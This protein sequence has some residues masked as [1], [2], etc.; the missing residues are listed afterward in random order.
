MNRFLLRFGVLVALVFALGLVGLAPIGATQADATARLTVHNR[1]CP[2]GFSGPDYYGT[3]HDTAPNPGLPFSISGPDAAAATTDAGGNVTFADLT[4]G[5]YAVS[6]G[7]PGEFADVNYFCAEADALAVAY[8]FTETA[9]GITV[10]LP[11]G[12]DVICDWYNTPINLSGLPTPTPA[13]TADLATLT[14]YAAICPAGYNGGSYFDDCFDNAA[15]AGSVTFTLVDGAGTRLD[16]AV[17]ADGRA[18]FTSLSGGTYVL[19]DSVPGDALDGRFV[20]CTFDGASPQTFALGYTENAISLTLAA[21][22]EVACDWYILPADLRGEPAPTVTATAAAAPKPTTTPSVTG[23]DVVGLPDTGSGG[24]PMP[25]GS[26]SGVAGFVVLFTLGSMTGAGMIL[27]HRR[28]ITVDAAK[29]PA[30]RTPTRPDT[31]R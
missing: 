21:G 11:A 15:D 20:Y 24:G 23:G 2:E 7:V 10:S 27:Q 14:V 29:I 28:Q 9:T 18:R 31:R 30:A 6:G 16:Q 5:D 17:G 3:C 4:A 26:G 22:Q 1:I 19:N 12:A 8:P 25:S 13:P